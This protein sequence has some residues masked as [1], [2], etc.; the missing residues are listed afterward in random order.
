M[1]GSVFNDNNAPCYYRLINDSP[2]PNMYD[3]VYLFSVCD[4]CLMGKTCPHDQGN[5]SQ[6]WPVIGDREGLMYI[7]VKHYSEQLSGKTPSTGATTGYC[8]ALVNHNDD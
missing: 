8:L 6:M 3:E 1:S 5:G 7:N 2:L 4:W